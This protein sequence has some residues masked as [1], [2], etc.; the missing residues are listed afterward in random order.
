MKNGN[1]ENNKLP[2]NLERIAAD[3]F[4][5][6][7]LLYSYNVDTDSFRS[8]NI[9]RYVK[10]YHP[11]EYEKTHTLFALK[12][13]DNYLEPRIKLDEIMIIHPQDTA[14]FGDY[15]LHSAPFGSMVGKMCKHKGMHN[16]AFINNVSEFLSAIGPHLGVYGKVISV[17]RDL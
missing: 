11:S 13:N 16:V 9:I 7:P 5:L 15:V 14:E 10:I 4:L 3:D 17:M 2:K 12:C 8:A 6:I 1:D